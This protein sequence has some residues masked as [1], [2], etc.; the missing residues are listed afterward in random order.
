[1]ARAAAFYPQWAFA[2]ERGQS[3]SFGFLYCGSGCRE[4]QGL[5]LVPRNISGGRSEQGRSLYKTLPCHEIFQSI[6][7][8]ASLSV[9][10]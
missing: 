1:M 6:Q 7:G 9:F 4:T 3:N 10:P 2:S 5:L 8:V